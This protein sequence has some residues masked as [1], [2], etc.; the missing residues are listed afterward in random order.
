MNEDEEMV[1]DITLFG[2]DIMK[3]VRGAKGED[4]ATIESEEDRIDALE[5]FLGVRLSQPEKDGI[6]GMVTALG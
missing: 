2:T 6:R 4:V 3:R 1:G 5:K